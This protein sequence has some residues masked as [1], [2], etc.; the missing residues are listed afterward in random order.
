MKNEVLSFYRMVRD[1][2]TVY[3]PKQRGASPNTAKS[4]KEALNIFIDYVGMVHGRP[5]AEISFACISR[6]LVDSFLMWLETERG[7]SVNSRNQRM[8]A[9]KSFFRYAAEKDKTLMSLYLDVEAIPKKKDARV[10]EIEFFSE[11]A[12]ETILA[13]PDRNKKN[14]QRDLFFMILMYDTGARAQEMLDLRLGDIRLEGNSPYVIITGKGAKTR[15]V[16]IME[17]TG[18]H[19]ESYRRRFHAAGNADEYLFY[20]DR[21]NIRS[22][23]SIDNVEKF[24]ARYGRMAHEISPDVPEHL[25]PHM[26]RH[27]RAM[28]LYRNGMP[29]P[30]VAEWLGH[31]KIDTTRMFYANADTSMKKEAIDKATSDI[32]PLFSDEYDIDWEDDEELLKKLYG[33]K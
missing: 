14:G 29:L 33:L 13:Q 28:H 3:L 18:R 4:Y 11:P 25:Y 6:P 31:A 8:S 16:P 7:Y 10:H 30:L 2:L 5:L 32:N 12:L 17:K 19:L 9:V 27:S 22:Q 15:H 23:M 1:F 24:V 20:I 21:K 26:W